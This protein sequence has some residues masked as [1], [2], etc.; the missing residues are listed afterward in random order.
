MAKIFIPVKAENIVMP[1]VMFTTFTKLED[2]DQ[3][4]VLEEIFLLGEMDVEYD[5]ND[6]VK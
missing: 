4:G 5:E 2:K 6:G 1:P 3:Y